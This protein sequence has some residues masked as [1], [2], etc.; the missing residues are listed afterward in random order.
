MNEA[1][2]ELLDITAKSFEE[3]DL[4]LATWVEPFEQS[5]DKLVYEMKKNHIARLQR[6]DC[7]IKL[8]FAF[9]DLLTSYE[10]VADHCSNIAVAVIEAQKGTY[11]P[12]GYLKSVKYTNKEEFEK[13]YREYRNRY[14]LKDKIGN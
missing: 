14:S 5:I 4:E 2:F 1:L 13:L 9:S 7:T 10:R 11:E 8:G 12:H 6:E 3:N